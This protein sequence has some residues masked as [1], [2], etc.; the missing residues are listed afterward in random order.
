MKAVE[1]TNAENTT[2]PAPTGSKKRKMSTRSHRASGDLRLPHGHVEKVANADPALRL[3][4]ERASKRVDSVRH[5]KESSSPRYWQLLAGRAAIYAKIDPEYAVPSALQALAST[6][7]GK[8]DKFSASLGNL[9]ASLQR[10]LYA[11]I[12]AST[13]MLG[14]T[15]AE[16]V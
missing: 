12:D 16:N 7:T 3:A 15:D 13:E 6:L 10:D 1:R 4:F 2:D 14:G 9:C 5:S 8:V 11:A